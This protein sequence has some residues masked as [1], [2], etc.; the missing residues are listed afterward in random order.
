MFQVIYFPIDLHR[1]CGQ[2]SIVDRNEVIGVNSCKL[3]ACAMRLVP[4]TLLPS[5]VAVHHV[6]APLPGAWLFVMVWHAY[7]ILYYSDFFSD[8]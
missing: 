4:A 7:S 3:I 1:G 8:T 2:V 5:E 6:Q